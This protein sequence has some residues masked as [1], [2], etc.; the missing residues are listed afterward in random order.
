MNG[1][2]EQEER[3]VLSR[4]IKSR[5]KEWL[6]LLPFALLFLFWWLFLLLARMK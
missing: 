1:Q 3:D 5:R 6:P 4:F 2:P